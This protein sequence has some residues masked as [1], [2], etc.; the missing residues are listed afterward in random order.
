MHLIKIMLDNFNEILRSTL[1]VD[2][3]AYFPCTITT[4][5]AARVRARRMLWMRRA[6]N[7]ISNDQND[8][9]HGTVRRLDREW[10]A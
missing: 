6:W 5:A 3:I 1:Y 10:S 2:T 8:S 4:V 7:Q 9:G